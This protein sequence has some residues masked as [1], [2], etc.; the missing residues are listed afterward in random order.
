MGYNKVTMIGYK[1]MA[2]KKET[3][4]QFASEIEAE[5]IQG[6]GFSQPFIV[7]S[8]HGFTIILTM[9]V[10]STGNSSV[11]YTTAF[12]PFENNKDIAFKLVKKNIFHR[13]F[14]A[15]SSKIIITGHDEFD[16][17]YRIKG[18]DEIYISRLFADYDLQALIEKQKQMLLSINKNKGMHKKLYK[19]INKK[20]ATVSADDNCLLYYQCTGVIKDK[21][22]LFDLIKLFEKLVDRFVDLNITHHQQQS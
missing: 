2:S 10:V 14:G 4:K 13:I 15:K 18:N 11:T 20:R 9:Y 16:N 3:W 7:Y 12:V 22:R 21:Q 1:T 19:D 6:K 5:Y 8:Y 17:A